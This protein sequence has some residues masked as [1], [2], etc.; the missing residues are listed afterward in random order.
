[1]SEIRYLAKMVTIVNED[2]YNNTNNI[3]HKGA[4]K[5]H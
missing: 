3:I 4:I 2:L 5:C 1:M